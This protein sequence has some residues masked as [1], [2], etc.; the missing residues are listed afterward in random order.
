MLRQPHEKLPI[1]R[2]LMNTIDR[3]YVLTA[4]FPDSEKSA[5]IGGL[6]KAATALPPKLAEAYRGD[7][8]DAFVKQVES[9]QS[10]LREMDAQLA[11]SARLRFTSGWKIARMRMR[12]RRLN[13]AFD[14]EI[15]RVLQQ[16]TTLEAA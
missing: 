6:R 14:H 1:W 4:S 7:D 2:R 12:L 13:A 8:P 3:I 10:A 15:E 5:M 9:V 11:I 16:H